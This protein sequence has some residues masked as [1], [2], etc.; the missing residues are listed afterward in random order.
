[1]SLGH[2]VCGLC[3]LNTMGRMHVNNG[4]NTRCHMKSILLDGVQMIEVRT[5]FSDLKPEQRITNW[6]PHLA[7]FVTIAPLF[8][9]MNMRAHSWLCNPITK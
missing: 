2:G 1:M 9:D 7:Y 3:T 8:P 5:S 6:K 4:R